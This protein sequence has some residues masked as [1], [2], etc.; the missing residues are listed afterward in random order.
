MVFVTETSLWRGGRVGVEAGVDVVADR[1]MGKVSLSAAER[2]FLKNN[3]EG[4]RLFI[5]RSRRLVKNLC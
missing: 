4:R 2:R 5:C 1:R 3:A